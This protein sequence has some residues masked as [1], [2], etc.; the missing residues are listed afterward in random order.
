VAFD[1]FESSVDS[2]RPVEVFEILAGSTP[3]NYTT[4][5][6]SQTIGATSYTPVRGLKRTPFADGPTKRDVDFQIELPT[7]DAV[8][9]LFVGNI[10]GI[11]IRLTA[12]KFQRNDTP[13]PEVI[14][15]FDGFIQSA[16]FKSQGKKCILT[17]RSVISALGKQIPRRTY[18]SACN[19]VLYDVATCQVD[20]TDSTY[21][22]ASVD[23][24]SASG[25]TLAIQTGQ[26]SG[27]YVDG[28]FNAGYVE[29][30]ASSDFRMVRAHVGD[31]LTLQQPF[32]TPPTSVNVLAGCAHTIA[33]CKSDFDNVNRFGG[34]AFVPTR[35]PF[36]SGVA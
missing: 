2:S 22:A 16:S 14:Q 6:D 33:V 34:F 36:Q 15:I 11:R 12:K 10:P 24:D 1:T 28:W 20:D 35:N 31:V 30:I 21:R 5:Q 29:D 19:H 4:A 17:A 27:T 13:T 23:V 7:S 32:S 9:Q 25:D 18:Q 3:Y 8:A 26:L